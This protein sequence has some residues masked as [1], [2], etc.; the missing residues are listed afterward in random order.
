MRSAVPKHLHPIL[1]RRM[2]DWVL[3]AARPLGPERLDRD[4]L[5]RLPRRLRRGR[6]SRCRSGHSAPATRFARPE[7]RSKA[8]PGACSSSPATRP[9]S[10][11]ALLEELLDT[12]RREDAGATVLSFEPPDARSLRA[13]R[14]GRRTAASARSSRRATRAPR[15]WRC[16]SATP[17]STSS[18][19]SCS[20]PRSTGSSPQNAQGELYLTDAVR[21]LVAEG[22]HGRRPRRRRPGA[23]PRAST[24]AS[25]WPPRPRSC[26]TGST[27]RTC[28]RASRS[29][30]PA[31]PG[32]SRR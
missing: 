9:S 20:G 19:P 32:S 11:H 27:T 6:R 17:R 26:A 21:D 24:R 15:S 30:I 31:R 13:G 28:L 16:G 7:P 29:S 5:A 18:A 2:V 25:S 1:G 23:R 14:P 4:R 8:R 22:I 10:R 3:E 12:H